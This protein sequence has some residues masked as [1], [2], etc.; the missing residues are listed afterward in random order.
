MGTIVVTQLMRESIDNALTNKEMQANKTRFGMLEYAASQGV[1]PKDQ[2]KQ[3]F[4]E[5]ST[6][7][8]SME[9]KMYD[10]WPVSVSAIDLSMDSTDSI[11]E[12]TVEFAIQSFEIV[13]IDN[14][15]K[16]MNFNEAKKW[17]RKFGWKNNAN[18]KS[19]DVL[20]F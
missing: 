13:Q 6:D 1:K 10:C 2:T 3:K 17:A 5:P 11:E 18:S 16:E 15:E 4:I 14:K 12:F 8:G 9:W 20:G 19:L 7:R